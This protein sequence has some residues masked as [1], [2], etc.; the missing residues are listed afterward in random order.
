[1][2]TAASIVVDGVA[3]G[4]VLFII[5][6]GLSLMLGLMRVVNLAH[7]AFAMVGGYIAAY[8]AR[9]LGLGFSAG[10]VAAVVGTAL[11][12]LPL[13]FLLY[14]RLYAERRELSQVLVTIGL[15]FVVIGVLNWLFGPTAKTIPLPA[16]LRGPVDLGF[17]SIPAHRIFVVVSGA[18]I[19]AGLWL[20]TERTGFGIRLRAV[21]DNTPMA[22]ALG[23]RTG[24][25]YTATF[26]LAVALAAFGG[27]AGAELLP[28]EPYYALR[29]MVTFL[30]VVSVAGVGSIGAALGSALLLGL[31]DTAAKYL[32]PEYGN[33]FLYLAV[34]LLV[35]LFPR[36]LS[37]K[38]A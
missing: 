25:L 12:A 19:A 23:V 22:A 26:M 11:F 17:R 29:H 1:M 35:L 18:L 2:Q 15:T 21:V 16:L 13:E 31:I 14:R 33:F 27:V 5:S 9:D 8:V 38:V 34:I 30:V 10:M 28:V 20:T 36:G 24:R 4:M 7:G 37:G 3:Y 6:I 32:A